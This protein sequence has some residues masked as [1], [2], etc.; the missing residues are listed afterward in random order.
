MGGSEASPPEARPSN[1]FLRTSCMFRFT[2]TSHDSRGCLADTCGQIFLPYCDAFGHCSSDT[3]NAALFVRQQQC[4]LALDLRIRK[5]SLPQPVL[6]SHA[7]ENWYLLNRRLRFSAMMQDTGERI[8][9]ELGMNYAFV[10][11][12]EEIYSSLRNDRSQ[13]DTPPPC[14]CSCSWQYFPIMLG[15]Q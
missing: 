14:V 1:P 10:C 5:N 13:V 6:L 2:V 8:A 12:F 7:D 4:S 11:E 3:S 9:Q 15:H